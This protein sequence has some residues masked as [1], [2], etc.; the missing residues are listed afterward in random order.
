MRL[1]YFG[2]FISCFPDLRCATIRYVFKFFQT[3]DTVW[4]CELT[5]TWNVDAG[6]CAAHLHVRT[7]DGT[8]VRACESIKLF[9]VVRQL[10]FFS[11]AIWMNIEIT[12]DT[13]R[14][15]FCSL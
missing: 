6:V 9:V 5:T 14:C 3:A 4:N 8:Y 7:I 10:Y 1:V 15:I 2:Y 13:I 12:I 11:Q